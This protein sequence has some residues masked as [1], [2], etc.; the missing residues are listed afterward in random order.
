MTQQ[1]R[2]R[3]IDD[4]L[5]TVDRVC[6]TSS[7]CHDDCAFHQQ[8]HKKKSSKLESLQ[9]PSCQFKCDSSVHKTLSKS[10]AA[11]VSARSGARCGGRCRH[12]KATGLRP[13]PSAWTDPCC[14]WRSLT[15]LDRQH[16][17]HSASSFCTT[18]PHQ[19]S[20]WTQRASAWHGVCVW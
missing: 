15:Q 16:H 6:D 13:G 18:E 20:E 4:A 19:V 7:F 10:R 5:A 8:G 9:L 14:W 12:A 11:R 3:A 2:V 1:C 17:P